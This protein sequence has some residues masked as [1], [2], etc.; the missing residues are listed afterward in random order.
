[1]PGATRQLPSL[2]PFFTPQWRQHG[3]SFTRCL[4][5]SFPF[6]WPLHAAAPVASP[7]PLIF[8]TPS[9]G[10]NADGRPPFFHLPE[11]Q[12]SCRFLFFFFLAS[13]GLGYCLPFF[14]LRFQIPPPFSR[15]ATFLS[16][17]G[18]QRRS[19]W[20]STKRRWPPLL[21]LGLESLPLHDG[22]DFVLFFCMRCDERSPPSSSESFSPP[23]FSLRAWIRGALAKRAE[24]L[25][26]PAALSRLLAF[27]FFRS[28]PPP[29]ACRESL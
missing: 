18:G 1:M 6:F 19:F 20:G 2:V 24:G 4:K 22:I 26:L 10:R 25:P 5:C 8:F 27:F 16:L 21:P 11:M 9:P 15:S 14:F 3:S 23:M 17:R 7:P 29:R 28:R 13:V 12:I